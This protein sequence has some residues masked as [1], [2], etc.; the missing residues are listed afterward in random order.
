MKRYKGYY[1]DGAVF[2]SEK[3]IDLFLKNEIIKK[4]KILSEMFASDR[5]T[6]GEKMRLTKDIHD[7]ERI[8]H[9]EYGMEWDEIEMIPYTA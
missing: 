4:I 3:E 7:R 1:I 9:D 5:Y 8:L 6:T 2:K